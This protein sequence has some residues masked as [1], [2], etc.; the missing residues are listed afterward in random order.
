MAGKNGKSGLLIDPVSD[1]QDEKP[2]Q[3]SPE[4]KRVVAAIERRYS[5][6][7]S[8]KRA[9]EKTWFISH[10]ALVGQHY[11]TWNDLT[12]SFEVPMRVPSH[13][14]RLVVNLMLPYYRRCHARLTAHRPALNVSPATTDELDV[15]RARLGDRVLDSEFERLHF[16]EVL[17]S[18]VSWMLETGNVIVG[19]RWDPWAGKPLTQEVQSMGEDPSGMGLE[20]PM[21]GPDG[22][23]VMETQPL[24]D[25]HGRQL[26]TGEAAL[27]VISPYEFEVDPRATSI[28]S[29]AWVMRNTV[30]T[31]EWIRD[32]Y[33][34][35]GKY[36]K[37]EQVWLHSMYLKRHKQLVG[38][39]GYT[40]EVSSDQDD[41]ETMNA[42]VVHEYWEKPTFKHPDGR[43]VVTANGI[44]LYDDEMPYKNLLKLGFWCPYIHIVEILIP[45]RFWGMSSL[46]QMFPLNR[47]L[48]RARSQEIENRQLHGRPKILVPRLSKIRQG[49]F[50]PEAGEKVDYTPG[51]RGEKPELIYPQSTTTATE[52]EIQHTL[53]DIQEVGSWHE[54]THGIMPSANAPAAAIDKLQQADETVLGDVEG[55][56]RDGIIRLGRMHLAIVSEFWSEE[57]TVKVT[58][59]DGAVAVQNIR[60]EDL[61]GDD[62]TNYYDVRMIPQSTMW[63][64]P[65]RQREMVADLIKL[66]VLNP[67][68]NQRQIIKMLDATS[69]ESELFKDERLDRDWACRENQ[70]MEQGQMSMPRDF[71]NH[72]LHIEEHNRYRKSD[73][74]RRLP[75]Q[76]QLLFDQHVQAHQET[77]IAVQQKLGMM[78][79]EAQQP[80]IEAQHA[81]A[82][83]TGGA[84]QDGAAGGPG[85]S[86]EGGGGAPPVAASQP[87]AQ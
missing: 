50:D 45:G 9:Y 25:D 33:P 42:A 78:E 43:L 47:N 79:M 62:T 67:V 28:D 21:M 35:K 86:P 77:I 66:Q 51:P 73:R 80:Q 82:A 14:V 71:E 70:L 49:A 74:Y 60:G 17:K 75:Q 58:G 18:L 5:E 13:R 32:H 68:Q 39:Y 46:E 24:M 31:I 54:A 85:G 64:D 84:T 15:E 34:D 20:I 3:Q 57:R 55:H 48:N 7:L 37:A 16:Q 10:A 53:M 19:V 61:H 63:K 36:V 30:R 29:A 59:T 44:L 41:R 40:A 8:I 6:K 76:L 87:G 56:L 1:E 83:A 27:D 72:P 22:K 26:H 11:L 65:I 4:E 2:Y 81:M 12:R 69:L 52:N 38:I 23:P